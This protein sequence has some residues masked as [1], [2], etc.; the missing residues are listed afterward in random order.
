MLISASSVLAGSLL[1][2]RLPVLPD[3]P[4]FVAML[5]VS[6]VC[7][8]CRTFRRSALFAIG[9]STSGLAAIL[10]LGDRLD[11]AL[12]SQT[13]TLSA[14]IE[15]FPVER[16]GAVSLLVRPVAADH[17]PKRLRLSWIEP[18]SIPRI[19]ETWHLDVRLRRPGGFIN[20]GGFDVEG[21]LFRR[22]I[23]AAGYIV[24]DGRNYRIAGARE[25][26]VDRLRRHIVER[27]SRL[28]PVDDATAVTLAVVAGARHG[29]SQN[30][31]DA[32]AETGTSH[33]MAISGLHIGL[34]AGSA[35]VLSWALLAL[36]SATGNCRDRAMVVALGAGAAYATLS[37]FAVPARRALLMLTIGVSLTVCRRAIPP[38]SLLGATA[39]IVTLTDPISVLAPGFHL[40]FAAVAILFVTGGQLVRAIGPKTM[41]RFVAAVRRIWTIQLAL[42]AGLLPFTVSHF[43]RVSALAPMVNLCVLPVFNLATVPLAIFGVAMDGPFAPLGDVFL[44]AAHGSIDLILA[45]IRVAKSAHVLSYRA[46]VPVSLA[47]LA[48][49]LIYVALPPGWPG[50]RIALVAAIFIVNAEPESTPE[51]CFD[52][53]VLDVGQGLAVLVRTRD[54]ALLFDA[55]PLFRNGSDAAEQVILPFLS[56][57]AV[58]RLDRVVI[59]HADLDHSGGVRSLRRSVRVGLFL[60][61]EPVAGIGS[62]R[63]PC[64]AGE[65]WQWNEIRFR[66]LHPGPDSPWRGNNASCV[67]EVAAGRH[68]LL[69]TGDIESP[70]E[71]LLEYRQVLRPVHA[72][73]VPHHGSRTS[74]SG[75][76]VRAIRPAVAIVSASRR[77]RWGFPKPDVVD[78]WQ[79]A[80][81]TVLDTGTAGAISQRLCTNAE[82]G[83]VSAARTLRSRYWHERPTGHSEAEF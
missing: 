47:V 42:L 20:P 52:Y 22:R 51:S 38:A 41:H 75:S 16:A 12:E 28:L 48:L 1:L 45:I 3:W 81:A 34:A 64:L 76:L 17:L 72:V 65:S 15:E 26:P 13:V 83:P 36:L 79:A 5:V 70:V 44:R 59:S 63:E 25:N 50:R 57:L 39:I 24:D 32:Y 6:L 40:S 37:G 66:I 58:E 21:W 73:T 31:W 27:L 18:A 49:P 2:N 30:Q 54:R 29:I 9:F 55:G 60:S 4:I 23:G 33:L 77:N 61:G 78:R 74:S 69:L 71:V 68:R 62:A 67:L 43:G 14:V 11:P 82:P 7:L 56:R 53:H 8:A 80:G 19:G 10:Q 35:Y 46:A